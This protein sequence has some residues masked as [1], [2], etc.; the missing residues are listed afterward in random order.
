M[1]I[2]FWGW[3]YM[4]T[5]T[6]VKIRK[7][8]QKCYSCTLSTTR[9]WFCHRRKMYSHL[10]VHENPQGL[11]LR[12]E[13]CAWFFAETR[14]LIRMFFYGSSRSSLGLCSGSAL[15]FEMHTLVSHHMSASSRGFSNALFKHTNS[16]YT[17]IQQL[18]SL[19]SMFSISMAANK[20][21]KLFWYASRLQLHMFMQLEER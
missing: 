1:Y 14:D 12:R 6:R 9:A 13:M 4:Q 8:L 7:K 15:L 16:I 10:V 5:E 3:I 18:G 17:L 11:R 19:P 21:I 20:C 2:D